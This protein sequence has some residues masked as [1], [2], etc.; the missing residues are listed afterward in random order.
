MNDGSTDNP[1]NLRVIKTARTEEAINEGARAGFRPLLMRVEP[2][3]E[4]RSKFCVWQNSLT[5][6]IQ[7]VGDYRGGP[8]DDGKWDKVLDWTDYYPHTFPQPFAAYLIPPDIRR[9]EKVFVEDLIEDFVGMSWNQGDNY[10]LPSS[11]AMWDGHKLRIQYDP[12]KDR[13]RVVG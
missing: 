6:E 2:S 7:V 10:R 13:R 12:E 1:D 5:R 11:I 4:I 9:G 8:R 3:A